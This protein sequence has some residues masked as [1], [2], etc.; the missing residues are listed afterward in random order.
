MLNGLDTDKAVS[1]LQAKTI[2]EK[3]CSLLAEPYFLTVN[4]GKGA[5]I[6]IK[7]CCSASIGVAMFMNHDFS[8]EEILNWA[9]AAMYQAKEAGRNQIQ[10]YQSTSE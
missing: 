4:Q 6:I 2:A 10:F 9:D 7:Y 8:N 3:I 5:D 1:T